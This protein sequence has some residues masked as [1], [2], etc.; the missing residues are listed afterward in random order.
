MF[1]KRRRAIRL[2]VRVDVIVVAMRLQLDMTTEFEG[3]LT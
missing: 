2:E 3:G 1:A